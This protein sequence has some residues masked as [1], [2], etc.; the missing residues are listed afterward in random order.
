VKGRDEKRS[1]AVG[2]QGDK[3]ENAGGVELDKSWQDAVVYHYQV[4]WFNGLRQTEGIWG[5][6]G[7]HG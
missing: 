3:G 5:F 7:G 2:K 4:R 6:G 1:G